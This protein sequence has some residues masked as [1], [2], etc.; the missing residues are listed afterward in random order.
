MR[1]WDFFKVKK[2][3]KATTQIEYWSGANI[4]PVVFDGEKTPFE[5]G[6]PKD[7]Y[8]DYQS[9][10]ARAWEAFIQS[11]IIQPVIKK[12]CLWLIGSGLKIQSN[13]IDSLLKLSGTQIKGYMA[14]VE[15]LFRLY[16]NT[17]TSTYS[18]M[19]NLHELAIEAFKNAILAGDVLCVIRYDGSN[20]NVEIIDGAFICTPIGADYISVAKARGNRIIEG[21]EIDA[22]GTHIAFYIQKD[23]F[24]WERISAYGEKT[25]MLQAWL[26]IGLRYKINKVRGMSLLTAVLEMDDKLNRYQDATLGS[27]EENAKIPYTIEH[28]QFSDGE[29]PLVKQ[30]AQSIGKG[31]GTAPETDSYEQA[32]GIA[33]KVAQTTSKQTYNMPIGSTLKRNNFTTDLSFKDYFSVN[34]DIIYI[35]LGFPPEVAADKFG[36]AYSGSRAALKSFE[37]KLMVDRVLY[38]K[39]Q[40]YKP[41]FDYWLDINVLENMI[42]EP[43]Y[44]EAIL[45]NDNITKEAFRNCR[46]IGATVPHIDPVKEVKAE[47]L[48]LGKAFDSVP[49]TTA[50]Q[51]CEQLNT[52]DFDQAIKKAEDEKDSAIY[53]NDFDKKDKEEIVTE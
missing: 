18:N 52:G 9:L 39:N 46:F 12:Y 24:Q 43:T 4:M 14:K 40:F 44:L 50:E 3:I 35:T 38:L 51:S 19:L 45:K 42:D 28:N 34:T 6:T 5:L 30:L 25:G 53:F 37:Y 11:P 48:K 31:K 41:I 1:F 20:V 29:S 27:A 2:E 15:A 8:L 22:K 36:G 21:V 13:P 32:E 26:F 49:L 16:A 17:K 47:R 10:R 33:T 7:I 23:D